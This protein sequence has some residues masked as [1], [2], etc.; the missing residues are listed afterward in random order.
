MVVIPMTI[1]FVY[2][3]NGHDKAAIFSSRVKELVMLIGCVFL[4]GMDLGTDIITYINVRNEPELQEF[5]LWYLVLIVFALCGG[6]FGLLFMVRNGI[7]LVQNTKETDNKITP[8]KAYQIGESRTEDFTKFQ[9]EGLETVDRKTSMCWVRI[10]ALILED[11][12]LG[13]LNIMIVLFTVKRAQQGIFVDWGA[14]K[15]VYISLAMN[16]LCVGNKFSKIRKVIELRET[17]RQ[18]ING[19]MVTT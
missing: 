13:I 15:M 19:T 17:R 18:L 10:G 11:I 9:A 12:P 16:L 8:E 14:L 2:R 4:D 7:I 1:Y 3:N 5:H 6:L